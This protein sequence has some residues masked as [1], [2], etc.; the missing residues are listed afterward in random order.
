MLGTARQ[1]I[2][3]GLEQLLFTFGAALSAQWLA[4]RWVGLPRFDAK[5]TLIS[6]LSLCLLLRVDTAALAALASVIAVA[7]KFVIR[8]RGRHVM[9]PTN[10]ALAAMMLLTDGAWVSPGQWGNVTLFAGALACAGILVVHR[11][12]R[13]DVTWA[14]LAAHALLLF[15]RALWLGDPISIPTHQLQSGGLVLFAFFMISDPKTTP[16]TRPARIVYAFA[17]ASLA[18]VLRFVRYEP[19]AL[20]WALVLCSPLVPIIDGLLARRPERRHHR[21]KLSLEAS[22]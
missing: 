2:H 3:I 8:V 12:E 9:N 19:N 1:T 13:S 11:A 6:S 5:S 15:G 10:F 4:S 22:A 20:I 7:S 14:F 18:Y 21:R 17:V 16:Q